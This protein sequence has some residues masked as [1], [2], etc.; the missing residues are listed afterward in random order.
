M[1]VPLTVTFAVV[2]AIIVSLLK[3]FIEMRVKPGL[4]LHDTLI[5]IVA[6]AVGMAVV[7][8]DY[9]LHAGNWQNGSGVEDALGRGLLVGIGS[10]I[11]YHLITASAFDVLTP[12][13][14]TVV[15]VSQPPPVTPPTPIVTVSTVNPE[16]PA[17]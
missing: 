15:T 12:G 16:P 9:T 6:I 3:V 7:L 13:E 4:V 1:N 5:R 11:S 2:T 10:I 8:A 14:S 17:V